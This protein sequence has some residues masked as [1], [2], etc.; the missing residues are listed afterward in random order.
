MLRGMQFQVENVVKHFMIR[1][2]QIKDIPC[3]ECDFNTNVRTNLTHHVEAVHLK[4]KRFECTYCDY[5]V[6]QKRNL[7]N[8]IKRNHEQEPKRSKVI[9]KKKDTNELM[10]KSIP[11]PS[12]E[13][14]NK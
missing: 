1:H 13:S 6:V 10:I 2:S 12:S 11:H 14:S 5:R 7:Q 9:E 8:H 3:T 4:N